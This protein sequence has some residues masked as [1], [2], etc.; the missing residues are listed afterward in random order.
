MSVG[1]GNGLMVEAKLANIV[2]KAKTSLQHTSSPWISEASP[3]LLYTQSLA[4][5]RSVS[6]STVASIGKR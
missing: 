1:E 5:T 6:P 2:A 3:C 4:I